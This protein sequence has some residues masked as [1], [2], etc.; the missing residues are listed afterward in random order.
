MPLMMNIEQPM[1]IAVV[2]LSYRFPG[3]ANSEE[4]LWDM[5]ANG[6]NAWSRVPKGRMNADAFY[7][8]D[9]GRKGTFY[10]CGAHFL[11]EDIAAFDAPFFSISAN[12][13]KAM[14]PQQRMLLEATYEAYENAGIRLEDVVGSKT[15]CFAGTLSNDYGGNLHKDMEFSTKYHSTGSITSLLANRIS[16]FFDLKGPSVMLDTA[17]SSSLVAFHLACQSLRSGE[18]T[19]AIVAGSALILSPD[20]FILLS[21][22]GFL[23]PDGKCHSFD[24][25]ANGYGRGEG[26]ASIILKPLDAAL[27]DGDPIRAIIRGTATNHDG[28]TPGIALPSQKSQEE[29]IRSAY[30]SAGLGMGQTGYFEA[31]GTGTQAGD[32]IETGAIGNTIGVTKSPG[33]PLLIGSIKSNIGHLE[34]ASGLAGIVKA[35]LILEKGLI[36]ATAGFESANPKIR[37]EEQNLQVVSKLTPWPKEGLRRISVNS[38]GFGGANAHVILDDADHYLQVWNGRDEAIS[39]A[40]SNGDDV[41]LRDVVSEAGS[42]GTNGSYSQI[43]PRDSSQIFV[44]SSHHEGGCTDIVQS[45]AKYLEKHTEGDLNNKLLYNLSYTLSE[46]RSK[47]MWKSFVVASSVTELNQA[48]GSTASTAV[49]SGSAP[50][51]AF[52]FSGQ[53]AQWATMGRE[54]LVFNCFRMS[55]ESA[56]ACLRSLGCEWNLIEELVRNSD[57]SRINQS[58]YSQPICTA[59]QVALIE[60]LAHLRVRPSA[61]VGH[62]SGEIAAAYCL[63]AVSR[64]A[65]WQIA[66][67]RGHLCDKLNQMKSHK[68]GAMMAANLSEQEAQEILDQNPKLRVVVACINSPTSVTLSGDRDDFETLES[69][70]AEKE[71]FARRLKVEHAYHSPQMQLIANEYLR[72]LSNMQ[73]NGPK[74]GTSARMFSSVTGAEITA[75]ELTPEYWVKNMVSP[76]KFTAAVQAMVHSSGGKKIRRGGRSSIDVLLEVGPHSTLK[77]PLKQILDYEKLDVPYF[78]LLTRGKGGLTTVLQATGGLFLRGVAVDLFR[79]NRLDQLDAPSLKVLTNLPSYPW[80]HSH[81]FWYESRLSYDYRHRSHPR[82][83]LLGAPTADH[84]T[85][86]PRWR[87]YLRV[88]ES[89]W[90][91]D[92]AVQSRIIYPGAGFIV[93]AIEAASQLADPLKKVKGFELRDVQINRA[94]QVPEEEEGVETILHL[95]PN[96]QRRGSHWD[97]FFIYSYQSKQ[98]WQDHARGLIVTHYHTDRVG[99]DQDREDEIQVQ[100]YREQYWRSSESCSST[101]HVDE[102]YNRLSQMGMQFGPAFRNMST[103]RH[104]HNQ[105]VCQLHIPDTQAQMPEESQF[106]HVIH[107]I[108]LDNIFHMV[109]P[110]RVGSDTSLRDAHVPVSLKSLYI[111]AD[112][113]HHPGTPLTGQSTVTHEDGSGFEATVVVSDTEWDSVQLVI[114]GLELKRLAAVSDDTLPDGPSSDTKKIVF[115]STWKE[116]VDLLNQEQA[117]RLFTAG[118]APG[119]NDHAMISELEHTALIYMKRFLGSIEQSDTKRLAPHQKL[120]IQWMQEQIERS[121]DRKSILDQV[122]EDQL[123]EQ[124]RIQSIDGRIMCR[125]GDH[126]EPVLQGRME[127]LEVLLHDNLLH[128]YYATGLGFDRVY[129]QLSVYLDRLVHKYPNMNFL[130][131]GAGT[132]GATLPVLRTLG[133]HGDHPARFQSYTFTDISSGFFGNAKQKFDDWDKYLS[134]QK[135]NIENDPEDQGFERHG[136]DVI[137]AANVL[138]ATQ[139]MNDTMVNVRKLLKPGGKLIMIEITQQLMRISMIMGVLPGWWLGEEDGRHGGPTLSATEWDTLLHQQGFKGVEIGL[140]DYADHQEDEL[141]SLIVSTADDETTVVS[142]PGSDILIIQPEQKSQKLGNIIANLSETLAQRGHQASLSTLNDLPPEL[143]NYHCVVL[144]EYDHPVLADVT[145]EQFNS[146]KRLLLTPKQVIWVTKGGAIDTLVPEANMIVGLARSIRAEQP[147]TLLSTLDLSSDSESAEDRIFDILHSQSVSQTTLDSDSCDYEFVERTGS[148]CISRL[149]EVKAANNLVVSNLSNQSATIPLKQ[150]KSALRLEVKMHGRLDSLQ[151]TEDP[152]INQRLLDNEVEVEVKATGVNFRDLMVAT[153]KETGPLGLECSGIISRVGPN[154]TKYK[155]GDRVWAALLGTYRS[156]V[157]GHESLFQLIPEDMSYETAAS[158]PFIYMT[159]YYCMFEV[160]RMR[161]GDKI[162]VHDASGGVG[163]AAIVL[164][165]TLD[166]EIFAT[167]GS[168]TDKQLIMDL[169]SLTEDHI[170]DSGDLNF[171]KGVK[172]MT[173]NR[174]VDVVLNSL[175]GEARRLSFEC[176][177]IFGRFIELSK[178]DGLGDSGLEMASFNGN[179]TFA[180]V[181]MT[182]VM[183]MDRETTA[184]ILEEM[185]V[186][187]RKGVIKEIYPVTVYEYGE[188][189]KVFRTMQSGAHVGKLVLQPTESSIVKVDPKSQ[190][191]IPFRS[192]ATYVL[193]GGLGGLGRSIAQWMVHNGAK[194]LV[195]ISRSG[196]QSPKAKKLKNQLTDAGATVA[197]YSCDVGNKEALQAVLSACSQNMPPIRGAIQGAMVLQDTLF[198]NMTAEK[199]H[200]A[201]RPKVQGSWNLHELLPRDLDFFTMLSSSAGIIGSRGQGNYGAGNTYQDAL[202]VYRRGQGLAAATIDLGVILDIGYVAENAETQENV[203]RWGFVGIREQEFHEILRGAIASSKL[204]SQDDIPIQLTT[205]LGTGGVIQA[206]RGGEYPYYFR[207]ARF[208]QLRNIDINRVGDTGATGNSNKVVQSLPAQLEEAKTLQDALGI[209]STAFLEKVS[210]LLLVPVDYISPSKPLHEYGVDSLVAVEIRNWVYHEA[211]SSVSVFDILGNDP[212]SALCEK[213]ALGCPLLKSLVD[214]SLKM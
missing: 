188:V 197:I 209:I 161:R 24:Q 142:H 79:A 92:H 7:H 187:L 193:A 114:H 154:V 165:K 8:P 75:D 73:D 119:A 127:P 17:C 76:V 150:S 122:S 22:P 166:A 15:A 89:P 67:H 207:D 82:H 4:A 110:S 149:E 163:Q 168:D 173:G 91:R 35:I 99:F 141:Y 174:G 132:G 167:V 12:E 32:P 191:P 160:A 14:D 46:R 19:S 145:G 28:K 118:L 52:V 123:I 125:V 98:G 56:G 155:T 49:K 138:H 112:I 20:F 96:R 33:D 113:K 115:R 151:F 128:E 10:A 159:A 189:E 43:I 11:Q 27:R 72:S 210:K 54:L 214:D 36:P 40:S 120:M 1:P 146:I 57:S 181:D 95:R 6:R 190:F 137:I 87:N 30:R 194:Y 140:P 93:M 44:A 18:A 133:G 78:N 16:W 97:E 94:L 31:H 2:G 34:G 51:L 152:E 77:G 202:A 192:D 212:I 147:K 162:L 157:R 116:D 70:L 171:A 38:F 41:P 50:S 108:T 185:A 136:Y 39:Y 139:T 102:F 205:G 60:L 47:L 107:P 177:A 5:L 131:I 124:T 101:I 45:L 55:L 158:L 61:V 63:G 164:A 13:A 37:L 117:S 148:I 80:M 204:S 176:L 65:A 9:N 53:G 81:R 213:I 199:F 69:I 134:Y 105:S 178:T 26:V 84:N 201:V 29:L 3:G 144:L 143:T 153:G 74:H 48:L 109:L 126:L 111:S 206:N 88:S 184:R 23:G 198:A 25:K 68:T 104:N 183:E 83:H 195:F 186:L 100:I 180:F 156:H 121:G 135:L 172:R 200:T 85:L 90:I 203:K 62:S 129:H 169:Y 21:G 182:M 208:S 66:Y 211:Q 64:E 59:V 170:F 42:D 86:E 103:I 58:A 175:T 106:N 71:V 196:P 130:E 179:T